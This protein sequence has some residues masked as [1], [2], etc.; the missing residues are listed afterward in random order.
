MNSKQLILSLNGL[1]VKLRSRS[2]V[3]DT[4]TTTGW[5]TLGKAVGFLIPFFIA[6]WFG[7]TSET[8]AFFFAYG[9][10][11]FLSGIFAPIVEIIIIPYIAEARAKNEDVGR[12]IG[13]IFGFSCV[14]LLALSGLFL[15][16]IK[17]ILSLITHFDS[18]TL[19]LVHLLLIEIAPL[20]IFLTLTSILAGTLNAYKKFT[21]P[22]V[23]PAFRATISLIIIF[24]FKNTLGVHSI[25][26]GYIIGEIFRLIILAYIVKKLRLFKFSLS[27]YFDPKILEFFKTA[28]Y[29]I[30]GTMI[31]G[32]SPIIDKTMATWLGEGS[33]SILHYADRLYSIPL[34]FINMGLMVVLLSHWSN[35]Y[36]EINHFRLKADVKRMIKIIGFISAFLMLFLI[37]F[38][39]PIVR[40]VF[41][42][43]EFD[44]ERLYEVAR[45]WVCY[46]FGFAPYIIGG[47]FVRAH[48]ILKNTKILMQCAFFLVPLKIF[49]NYILMGPFKIAGLAIANSITPIFTILYLG[50]LFYKMKEK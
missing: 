39:Q 17:P 9:L 16:I 22:A 8:D 47:I 44:Q 15:L 11:L 35:I 1:C 26:L 6:A 23:S 37:L 28:S 12:F 31:L 32:L 42:R 43:G 5:S 38:N 41:G 20:A 10:I 18:Q 25:A 45:V 2:L 50:N 21:F 33:V 4:I 13:K 34:I 24:I 29:Q 46:L 3:W 14:C 7:V 40:M 19:D 36:Y 48:L 49:L 27:F 30:V